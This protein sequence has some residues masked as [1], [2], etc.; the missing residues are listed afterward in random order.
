MMLVPPHEHQA[1]H[2]KQN[3][4]NIRR[5]SIRGETIFGTFVPRIERCLR[6]GTV[7]LLARLPGSALI[8]EP[9]LMSRELYQA[10][11]DCVK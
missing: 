1:Q 3:R 7:A 5:L 9:L 6:S 4:P 8:A 2:R 11:F 10:P